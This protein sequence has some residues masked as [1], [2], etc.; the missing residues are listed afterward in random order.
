M[1][2]EQGD[3]PATGDGEEAAPPVRRDP[4]RLFFWAIF[5]SLSI[6][7]VLPLFLFE[8]LP[9]VDTSTHL[10]MVRILRYAFENPQDFHATF[11]TRLFQPYWGYY[12]PVLLLST[13]LPIELAARIALAGILLLLPVAALVLLRREGADPWA[14]LL[15]FPLVYSFSFW[16]G[17]YPYLAGVGLALLGLAAVDQW[18]ETPTRRVLAWLFATSLGVLACQGVAW[19]F[20][21]GCALFLLLT[22][23]RAH[24]RRTLLGAAGALA[25]PVLLLLAYNARLE[26]WGNLAWIR[27]HPLSHPFSRRAAEFL[28][29]TFLASEPRTEAA[30]LVLF[31][32]LAGVW[33]VGRGP[34]LRPGAWRWAA[35]GALMIAC[36]WI[37]PQDFLGVSFFYQRF[38][39]LGFFFLLL[40]ASPRPRFHVPL[41]LAAAALA[42]YGVFNAA[43]ITS[44]VDEEMRGLKECLG[45]AAPKTNLIGLMYER[46]AR[47]ADQPF[48]LHADNYHVYWNGGRVYAHSMEMLSTT[49]VY[50]RDHTAFDRVRPAFDWRPWQFE[51]GPMSKNVRYFLVHGPKIVILPG[52]ELLID[53]DATLLKKDGLEDSRRVCE[54]GLWRLYE[55]TRV[56]P[57]PP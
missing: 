1:A 27:E 37:F 6:L 11:G 52:D 34:S 31:L 32:V 23:R 19:F 45:S 57:P 48:F 7:T 39:Q 28:R 54:S 55:N 42:F 4:H 29:N 13:V 51:Y 41:G 33:A 15:A 5:G 24:R 3:E 16:W 8:F 53:V 30:L 56:A 50:W 36:Y 40:A 47:I 18:I 9:G 43:V 46:S 22:D 49:P 12:A 44:G 10:S 26:S 35:L 25:L 21:A 2:V 38:P 17:F 14:S 20:W